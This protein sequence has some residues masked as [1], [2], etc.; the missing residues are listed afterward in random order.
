MKEALPHII[1]HLIDH[2][3]FEELYINHLQKKYLSPKIARKLVRSLFAA[4]HPLP[5]VA[6]LTAQC[7][8]DPQDLAVHVSREMG[9]LGALHHQPRATSGYPHP[10]FSS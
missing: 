3:D 4:L 7:S 8:P 6:S 5:S 9:R 2:L 10:L 1:E